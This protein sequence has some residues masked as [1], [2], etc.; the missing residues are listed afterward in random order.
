MVQKPLISIIIPAY[1]EEENLS[2]LK[3][4]LS[5]LLERDTKRIYEIIIVDD[6]SSDNTYKSARRIFGKM[7]NVKVLKHRANFGKTDAIITGFEHSKGK[8][9][10]ILDAD[11]Q[12][13]AMEIPILLDKLEEGYDIIS[14]W[15]MG[16]YEKKFVSFVYNFLSR[17]LFRI[18]V[19]DQNAM[20]VMKREVLETI[21]LRKEWHRYI[22]TL[23]VSMGFK[24][25]EKK[26][27]LRPRYKGESKYK[28]KGRI[29]IG[30]LDLIAVKFQVSFMR[31]PMLFFGSTGGISLTLG[32]LV[33]IYAIV[34]R[35][36]FHHG[37]R[38]LLYLVML[39]VLVGFLLFLFGFLAE[40]IAA[41]YD[42]LKR[43]ER[44]G[45]KKTVGKT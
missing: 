2:A 22:V 24:A 30:L 1:N 14:G 34:L 3:K 41:L 32:F 12:Y 26:V 8:Y 7:K 31:K 42:E 20:K 9:I 40:G 21:P 37:Y 38:P 15:K 44:K 5:L 28:G 6:G 10:A 33:G 25:S 18:P 11:L 16:K 35:V 13:D 36:G 4:N 29:I 39:L 43:M 45:D 19:H 27:S 23:A 17:L